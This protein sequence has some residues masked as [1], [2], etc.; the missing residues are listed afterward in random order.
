MRMLPAGARRM[1]TS[2]LPD[3]CIKH[4]MLQSSEHVTSVSF[5]QNTQNTQRQLWFDGSGTRWE[6]LKQKM[7]Q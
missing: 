5:T 4:A 2:V 6:F 3:L 7:L 1:S